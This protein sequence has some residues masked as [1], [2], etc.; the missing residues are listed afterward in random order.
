M[1]NKIKF[2]GLYT[3]LVTPFDINGHLDKEG[4]RHNIRH[5]IENL[6]DG[7]VVLGSTGESPTISPQ[8]KETIISTAVE[9]AKG[10]CQIIVGTGSYSTEQT[11]RSTLQAEQM[12]ADGALIVTPYY[13]KPTQEGIYKHFT[14][15]CEAVSIPIC[16]YNIQ[17]RTGINL[18][19]DTLHRLLTFPSI[20]GIKDSSGNMMQ[21]SEYFEKIQDHP[22][23]FGILSGDDALTLPIIAL[24]GKGVI[25]VASNLVPGAV[26]NLVTEALLG[27]V[28]NAQYWHYQLL[29]LFNALFIETNPAP[30]KAA[31]ELCGM[32]AGRCRMPLC[33]LDIKNLHT[34]KQL[35]HQ[36]PNQW[37]IAPS[38]HK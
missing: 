6:V 18:N 15:I 23:P 22:H 17:S 19:S 2:E 11:I 5:Q 20:M 9:E 33:D 30:I 7:I 29:P 36:L 24:G 27:N 34:L 4:L 21:I 37:L 38:K 16:I 1:V 10:K 8:E 28:S 13:N 3:A 14:A 32:A 12:G 25:S 35:I 26:K 31:M